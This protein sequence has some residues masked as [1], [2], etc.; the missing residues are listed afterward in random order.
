M[1]QFKLFKMIFL[2]YIDRGIISGIITVNVQ[3]ES[4]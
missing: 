3:R 2:L 4:R 1:I